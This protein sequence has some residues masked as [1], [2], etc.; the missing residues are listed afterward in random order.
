MNAAAI[1]KMTAFF[2][3]MP[4]SYIILI[5]FFVD[6]PS[7]AS[8]FENQRV[9]KR[10]KTTFFRRESIKKHAGFNDDFISRFRQKPEHARGKKLR[11]F[12][13]SSS[14][15]RK[16]K[17][18][19]SEPRKKKSA[20]KWSDGF[21]FPIPSMSTLAVI[22]G[23]VVIALAAFNWEDFNIKTPESFIIRLDS[24]GEAQRHTMEYASTGITN[25][26][27]HGMMTETASAESAAIGDRTDAQNDLITFEWRQYRVKRGDS[28]SEIA[29]NFSVS[30][31]AIIASN[32][33][34]NARILQEGAVIRIPNI[35]G[36]P[37]Q[38]KSGDSLQKI[39][40]SFN[41]PLEVILDVNDIKSD[42]I[43]A[44]ETL[45]IPGGRMNDLDLR[46][47]LGELFI[48]PVE[49]RY[50]TSN[51]GMRK[52]PISGAL[53]F[54]T[55]ID[56]RAGAGAP[57]SAALDGLVSVVTENWLYGKYI[58]INHDNGYKTLYGHLNSFSVKQGD[59]VTRGKKVGEAGNTGY[60]T[61]AHL[62]FSVYD[63]SNKLVNP[64]D[65][66]R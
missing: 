66:L 45:F 63:K 48:Y 15:A 19:N 11:L 34:R 24:G 44:G 51:F 62:H 8:I 20:F 1:A 39:A 46:L 25:V 12:A 33:I 47:S 35:D 2:P 31:G 3:F 18:E 29:K 54:H 4:S 21:S 14:T 61:G 42:N 49:S 27:L 59:R 10:R 17:S 36:I 38:V 16:A 52:D 58:I 50:I 9:A 26:T 7:M 64:L 13:S 22:A 37:Y 57:V 30:T 53:S 56:L 41:V 6:K 40:V 60:S 43:K 32:E 55:G 23:T 28:V 65:L 5:R